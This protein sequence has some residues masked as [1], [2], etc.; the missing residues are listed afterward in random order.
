MIIIM[1]WNVMQSKGT[2]VSKEPFAS[3][4]RVEECLLVGII[5]I[6]LYD[7]ALPLEVTPINPAQ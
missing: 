1:F 7:A 4:F 5:G 3:M 2:Y 6:S